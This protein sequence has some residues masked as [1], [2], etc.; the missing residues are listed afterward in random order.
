[1]F[2][3][4][5]IFRNLYF[6]FK[7]GYKFLGGSFKT[8]FKHLGA[9]DISNS[10]YNALSI[11][12]SKIHL[13][14]TDV[15]IDIGCGKGR[16]LNYWLYIYP[17]NQ[18]IGIELDNKI[19]EITSQRLNRYKNV[20]VIAGNVLNNIPN[21]ASIFFLFNPFTCDIMNEFKIMLLK[22]YYTSD[23]NWVS[24][25]IIILYNPICLHIFVNDSSF[26]CIEI[27]MPELYHKCYLISTQ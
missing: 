11:I 8:K 4:T 10:D 3:F 13:N 6:D 5:R 16:V 18:I 9:K 21:N 20:T 25:F 17:K 24:K 22:K 26:N 12:F 1:M 27:L 15:L 14:Q 7:F 23:N 2:Y 19:A